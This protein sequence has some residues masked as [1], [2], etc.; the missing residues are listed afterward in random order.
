MAN[1]QVEESAHTRAPILNDNEDPY[2]IYG[3]EEEVET[4]QIS[5]VHK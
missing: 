3:E 2:S 1:M 4:D 5:L